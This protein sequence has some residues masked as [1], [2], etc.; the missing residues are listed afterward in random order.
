MA[1]FDKLGE[2]ISTK[3]KIV[4]KKA[5]EFAEVTSLNTQ[6]STEEDIINKT[7]TE[8]GKLYFEQNKDHEEDP[9][10]PQF[11]SIF[12]AQGHI[13]Q[14]R[15]QIEKIKGIHSCPFCGAEM[16]AGA[17]FCS[18]CGTKSEVPAAEEKPVE[19]Q[20][21]SKTCANCGAVLPENAS[22]CEVCGTKVSVENK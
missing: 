16:Q 5:K 12:D 9:F 20:A 10:L 7:Y 19:V 8:I 22:F 3:S 13:E 18:S 14:L 4:A 1:I 6:I 15:Q 17:A 2:T 11:H 21:S